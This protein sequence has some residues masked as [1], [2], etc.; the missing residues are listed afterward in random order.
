MTTVDNI[1]LGWY[2]YHDLGS[3]GDM[4]SDAPK[5]MQKGGGSPS[6]RRVRGRK[7]KEAEAAP[8]SQEGGR[9]SAHSQVERA[10]RGGSGGKDTISKLVEVLAKLSL[11]SSRD[12]AG[13]IGAIYHTFLR[14]SN[15]NIVEAVLLQA[16]I[17]YNEE[18]KALK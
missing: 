12:L 3:T 10:A 18:A 13:V 8:A 14:Q 6:D 11:Q 2:S 5:W 7:E 9:G 4:I 17:D 1:C 16:G 15:D